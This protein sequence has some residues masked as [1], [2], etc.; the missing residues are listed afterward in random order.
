SQ[1]CDNEGSANYNNEG[2]PTY[3]S[4]SEKYL[5]EESIQDFNEQEFHRNFHTAQKVLKNKNNVVSHKRAL[6]I[7]NNQENK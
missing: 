3:T 7:T 6:N 1:N 2:L 4:E 5:S